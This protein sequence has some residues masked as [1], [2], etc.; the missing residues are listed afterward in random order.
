MI[1]QYIFAKIGRLNL[2]SEKSVNF[3][4]KYMNTNYKNA[5][6]TSENAEMNILIII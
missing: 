3:I 6:D 5:N 2:N 1:K 4:C